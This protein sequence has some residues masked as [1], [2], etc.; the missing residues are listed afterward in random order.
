MKRFLF[1]L[2]VLPVGFS[3]FL[4]AV[5]EPANAAAKCIR[6]VQDRGGK[7]LINTC[8]KCRTASLSHQRPGLGPPITRTFPLPAK[9]KASL[10]FKGPG[11]TRVISESACRDAPNQ[12]GEKSAGATTQEHCVQLAQRRDGE[13]SFYNGCSVCRMV[14]AE[15]TARDGAKSVETYGISARSSLPIP[16]KGA[17][18]IRIVSDQPCP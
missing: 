3:A 1:L 18:G 13:L 8:A 17:S 15:R 2:L 12:N 14:L 6:L 4:F 9:G 5:A 10:P 11:K 16:G 7:Y